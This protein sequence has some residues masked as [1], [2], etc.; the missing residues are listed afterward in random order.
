MTQTPRQTAHQ[1]AVAVGAAK[2]SPLVDQI[3]QLAVG[4]N[5]PP[6]WEPAISREIIADIVIAIEALGYRIVPRERTSHDPAGPIQ[7]T[8]PQSARADP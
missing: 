8:L 4:N 2:R 1:I 7:K 6:G 5:H 3:H